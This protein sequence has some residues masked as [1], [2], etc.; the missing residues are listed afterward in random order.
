MLKFFF[1]KNNIDLNMLITDLDPKSLIRA[2][3][4]DYLFF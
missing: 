3:E 4:L 2:D 1:R